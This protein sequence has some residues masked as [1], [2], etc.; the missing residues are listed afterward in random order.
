[1]ILYDYEQLV[2]M[3]VAHLRRELEQSNG[4]KYNKNR[5]AYT[6]KHTHTHDIKYLYWKLLASRL[7]Y[8]TITQTG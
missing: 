8:K 5:N 2:S 1:M 4:K 3:F 6:H 7:I